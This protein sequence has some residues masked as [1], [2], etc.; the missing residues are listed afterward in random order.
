[1]KG[2]GDATRCAAGDG[3]DD[4]EKVLKRGG[5]YLDERRCRYPDLEATPLSQS[6]SSRRQ[7]S[8]DRDNEPRLEYV[9]LAPD[10]EFFL[11]NPASLFV[12]LDIYIVC[13]GSSSIFF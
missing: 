11:P 8:S 10:I 3:G 4:G 13:T 1:M 7:R 5:T 2:D 12:P 6:T 9:G